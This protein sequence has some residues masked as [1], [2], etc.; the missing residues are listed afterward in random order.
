MESA[1]QREERMLRIGCPICRGCGFLLRIN[2]ATGETKEFSCDHINGA[3]IELP[4]PVKKTPSAV[5][6]VW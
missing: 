1:E 2:L 4:P 6:V 3:A 5:R